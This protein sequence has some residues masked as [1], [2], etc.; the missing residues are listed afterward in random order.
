MDVGLVMLTMALL[1]VDM[2][3]LALELWAAREEAQIE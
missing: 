1:A 3:G 2:V